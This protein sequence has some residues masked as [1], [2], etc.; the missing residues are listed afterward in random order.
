[1]RA[2]HTHWGIVPAV[3]LG[4]VGCAMLPAGSKQTQ[5]IDIPLVAAHSELSFTL[6]AALERSLYCA[7]HDGCPDEPESVR[8]SRFSRQVRDASGALQKAAEAVYPDLEQRVPGLA[9]GQFEVYETEG[10]EPGSASS[11]SGRILLNTSLAAWPLEDASVAF[12]IAREMGHVI[13]RHHEENSLASLVTSFALNVGIP[14]S[15]LLKSAATFAGSHLATRR[16]KGEQA[17]AADAIALD[18]LQ[19]AGYRLRDVSRNVP[20]VMD[21]LE[22]GGW[23]R[24]FRKSCRRLLA[25]DHGAG[26]TLAS[27]RDSEAFVGR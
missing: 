8:R 5:P 12:I 24:G 13:L 22:D 23:S 3:C 16:K 2:A 4:T 11:A 17:V 27:A 14:G 9:N 19:V 1:M 25:Q 20:A 18:L 15:S 6:S 21:R 10:D 7:E 26:S